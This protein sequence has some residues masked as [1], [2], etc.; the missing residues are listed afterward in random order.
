VTDYW[1]IDPWF[2][3]GIVLPRLRLG[4]A[5]GYEMV[6]ST[7]EVCTTVLPFPVTIDLPALTA[8]RRDLLRRLHRHI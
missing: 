6:D 8:G 4:A 7:R 1:I 2:D 3:E 5:G